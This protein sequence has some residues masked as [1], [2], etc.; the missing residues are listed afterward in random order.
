V[1]IVATPLEAPGGAR[2]RLLAPAAAL[3][4]YR[5]DLLIVAGLTVVAALPRVWQLGEVPPGLHGDEALTGLDAQ[6]IQR[7]GWIGPYVGSAL[8]QPTGP[9]YW[10]AAF[11]ELFGSTAYTVRLSMAVLGIIGVPALYLAGRAMFDRT[12][13][14]IAALILATMTWHIH[15]SRTAFMVVAWP[16]MEA[17]A[18]ALLFLALNRGRLWLFVPAG[19]VLGAGSL[20]YN[21]YPLFIVAVGFFAVAVVIQAR[22][23]R[24]VL[25]L[26]FGVYFAV[27]AVAALPLLL[28]IADSDN[29]Y[30]SHH[31][32]YSYLRTEEYT[33]E[34]TAGRAKLLAVK[35]FDWLSYM[36]WRDHAD[37]VD[38][39]GVRPMLDPLTVA[40]VTGGVAIALWRGNRPSHQMLL[41]MLVLLPA[42][43]IVSV[44]GQFR[45]A[46]GLAPAAALLAAL[47]LALAW[48]EAREE[49]RVLRWAA[50][51]GV[52]AVVVAVSVINLRGY[53]GELGSSD[54]AKWV[55]A[56]Q[57][58]EASKYID[59]LPEHPY[60]YFYS[61]RWSIN[62]ETRQYLAP[63]AKGEDRSKEFGAFSLGA[64]RSRDLL[65]VFIP[66]YTENLEIVQALYPGGETHIAHNKDGELLFA[67]YRLRP[68]P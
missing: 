40:L 44:D 56:E 53:F 61:Q 27:A 6:R 39:A 30:F 50:R 21:V 65:Y 57:L 36:V 46:L 43:S 1:S 28:F 52:A 45:R 35:A 41:L 37:F 25:L 11:L 62:Y 29:N 48:R 34:D 23:L 8:G 60:V 26:R 58:A 63:N 15:Y 14:L 55:Y 17:L 12:T 66:P 59:S 31:R 33:S 13:G 32:Q 47:P 10:A 24:R 16:L 20:S 42:A 4:R 54:L 68:S 9:L 2:A 7:E 19:A 64:D 18:L 51:A 3:W 22:A 38:A 5:A 49:G 67:A